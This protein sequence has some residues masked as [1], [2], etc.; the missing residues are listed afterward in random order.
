MKPNDLCWFFYDEMGLWWPAFFEATS[1]KKVAG[2]N[3]TWS[4]VA[5]FH[6]MFDIETQR[7]W[8]PP[9]SGDSVYIFEWDTPWRDGIIAAGEAHEK[10]LEFSTAVKAAEAFAAGSHPTDLS[11]MLRIPTFLDAS[12]D[13]VDKILG[14]YENS[15]DRICLEDGDG[16]PSPICLDSGDE[17]DGGGGSASEGGSHK[18]SVAVVTPSGTSHVAEIDPDIAAAFGLVAAVETRASFRSAVEKAKGAATPSELENTSEHKLYHSPEPGDKAH[19]TLLQSLL[20]GP[21]SNDQLDYIERSV[22][23]R[24]TLK[25]ARYT[26]AVVIPFVHTRVIAQLVG[27]NTVTAYAYAH[28]IILTADDHE[29]AASSMRPAADI[30]VDAV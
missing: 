6:G 2:G 8:V 18:F 3:E 24:F 29:A 28:T 26:M 11:G 20:G 16:I 25:E 14:E 9:N 15:G 19:L 10:S 30:A 21:F 17:N 1:K 13:E 5:P 22:A 4:L 12:I 7:Y 27:C 23:L